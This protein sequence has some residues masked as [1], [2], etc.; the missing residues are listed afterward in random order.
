LKNAHPGYFDLVSSLLHASFFFP[1][2]SFRILALKHKK[3]CRIVYGK[4]DQPRDRHS[5]KGQPQMQRDEIC[6]GVS[7]AMQPAPG[8]LKKDKKFGE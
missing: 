6:F 2:C 1:A 8:E 3:R 4:N 7:F 5:K